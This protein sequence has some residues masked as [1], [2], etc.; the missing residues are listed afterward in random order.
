M[1]IAISEEHQELARVARSFLEDHAARTEARATLEEDGERK[2][3]FWQEMADLG[4]MGLHIPEAAEPGQWLCSGSGRTGRQSR[5][6]R[7][8]NARW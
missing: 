1:S 2:P 8:G 5:L 6:E 3:T 7:R 4:W